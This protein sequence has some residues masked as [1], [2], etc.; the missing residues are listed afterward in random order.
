MPRHVL[1]LMIAAAV[2]VALA[3][4]W[5]TLGRGGAGEIAT[6]DQDVAPFHRLEVAGPVEVV[7]RQGEAEHVSVET[8]ARGLRIVADVRGD[9][10]GIAVRDT[11]RWWSFFAGRGGGTRTARVVVTFR[12]LDALSLSGA[13]KL[14]AVRLEAPQLRLSASGGSAVHIDGLRADTLRVSGSGALKAELAGRA[15][16]Q[17]IAISGA[18]EYQAEALQSDRASISVSGVGHVVVRV[19]KELSASISGAG[20][21]EYYGTPTVKERISG[22]GRVRRIDAKPSLDRGIR[23][24]AAT[25]APRYRA[26]G[27]LAPRSG[28]QKHRSP[29]V[30]SRSG[31]IDAV[32]RTSATRQ[33]RS[34]PAIAATTSG[35]R[36]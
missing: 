12:N 35:V 20:N 24:A 14:S 11:R 28:L 9:T 8:P 22:M 1:P 7:L 13:V 36:S 27:L 16:E 21:V 31:W 6:A 25:R 3:L 19:E 2:A 34:S 30:G 26:P 23:V 15:T 32:V 29:V 4:T 18:G 5:W 17:H 33:S 10:L